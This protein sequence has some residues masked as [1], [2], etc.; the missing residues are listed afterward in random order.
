MSLFT[1]SETAARALN[2]GLR[3][4]R[5][6]QDK[7]RGVLADTAVG[8][9]AGV[10]DAA[11]GV[12]GLAD[13]LVG[14]SLPDWT[15]NPF[16]ERSTVVGGLAQGLSQF[17]VGFIPGLG[18]ASKLGKVRGLGM[19]AGT[20]AK[21]NWA[22]GALGGALADFA[23]FDGHD[24]RLSDM[25]RDHP[26][27]GIISEFL[28]SNENDHELEGRLKN[29]LEG[30]ALDGIMEGLFALR[31][32]YAKARKVVADGGTAD[33]AA[34]A[35]DE[36]VD[37]KEVRK[38]Q[39][40][41][42]D[43]IDDADPS[44]PNRRAAEV[45]PL[46]DVDEAR[47]DKAGA[48]FDADINQPSLD[49]A[50]FVRR[51]F[52]DIRSEH[53]DFQERL[54]QVFDGGLEPTII[55]N[56][57]RVLYWVGRRF[58]EESR[59]GLLKTRGS[60]TI[61]N[62]AEDVATASVGV[63]HAG[64]I[65][66]GFGA[67]LASKFMDVF[68]ENIVADIRRSR[69]AAVEAKLAQ[70]PAF[71]QRLERNDLL[72]E[73]KYLRSDEE[74]VADVGLGQHFPD[75]VAD[76]TLDALQMF[77]ESYEIAL[78][79]V[80]NTWGNQA[81]N[82]ALDIVKFNG[83]AGDLEEITGLSLRN[84]SDENF[85][86]YERTYSK[87]ERTDQVT[88]AAYDLEEL[89]RA[90]DDPA[91]Y[92]GHLER[93]SDP[94]RD[95]V[96]E[97]S[98]EAKGKWRMNTRMYLQG[99][100]RADDGIRMLE[101][102]YG[103][104]GRTASRK[105]LVE[106]RNAGA[107]RLNTLLGRSGRGVEELMTLFLEEGR[108]IVDSI[109]ET[110]VR[111]N[112]Y[113]EF[114]HSAVGA[115]TREI[116]KTVGGYGDDI[117]R[118]LDNLTDERLTEVHFMYR[119]LIDLYDVR[120]LQGEGTGR[121]LRSM[122]A[123][124]GT[125]AINVRTNNKNISKI[126]EGNGGREAM[127]AEVAKAA[128][129]ALDGKPMVSFA[130]L[131]RAKTV[132]RLERI[133]DMAR[134]WYIASLLAGTRTLAL[135]TF[136]IANMYMR[137][138]EKA[139]GAVVG[140]GVQSTAGALKGKPGSVAAQVAG[141]RIRVREELAAAW[142]E[143]RGY[144]KHVMEGLR[145]AFLTVKGQDVRLYRGPDAT[146]V[147]ESA[148]TARK[149]AFSTENAKEVLRDTA[150]GNYIEE[151]GKGSLG[152]IGAQIR[153][154]LMAGGKRFTEGVG[155]L[156]QAVDIG[157]GH[158]LYKSISENE[159][160]RRAIAK[161]IPSDYLDAHVEDVMSRMHENWQAITP[162]RAFEEGQKRG[163]ELGLREKKLKD[164]AMNYAKRKL[165]KDDVGAIS[166]FA[167]N[168]VREMTWKVGFESETINKVSKMLGEMPS[169]TP[170][171]IVAPFRNTP[172]AILKYGV[173]RSPIAFA[174]IATGV[175]AVKIG[176]GALA[177]AQSKIVRELVSSDPREAAQAY[178]K[179]ATATGIMSVG[180]MLAGA[181]II[182]G[183]GP[184]NPAERE[185]MMQA[186]WRPYSIFVGDDPTNPKSGQYISFMKFEQVA[187]SMALIADMVESQRNGA[188]VR[189]LEEASLSEHFAMAL[190]NNVTSRSY[191][192]GLARM[193]EVL[194]RP[195]KL[196]A[197]TQ[198]MTSAFVPNTFDQLLQGLP[199][200]AG[201]DP[202]LREVRS[203]W[204]AF[205]NATI[206]GRSKALPVRRNFMGEPMK[207]R[208]YLG[209]SISP[210][211]EAFSFVEVSEVSDDIIMREIR[212]IGGGFQTPP[213]LRNGVDL[214]KI[215]NPDGTSVY[216]KW[217]ERVSTV[218]V[219]DK[220]LRQAL[221]D[222]IKSPEYKRLDYGVSLGVEDPHKQLIRNVVTRYRQAAWSD[223]VSRS[224]TLQA[225]ETDYQIR[226]AQAR[227]RTLGDIL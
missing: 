22:R 76:D 74:Y 139:L 135:N 110:T 11:Q 225:M 103:D 143:V 201:G 42:D 14:D 127:I 211:I 202:Y 66:R 15:G 132:G 113:A 125:A 209:G 126:I 158:V 219:Q 57:K 108:E 89:A 159:I 77:G 10:H 138:L 26:Q 85:I 217:A 19:L 46:G 174:Q 193:F 205:A 130:K 153:D 166:E 93:F 198:S 24:E 39:R 162:A 94:K 146:I 163:L 83:Q 102:S 197:F 20:S 190:I 97:G 165:A 134:D 54:T 116:E 160:R 40:H 167:L 21:A 186:G 95:G 191:L 55:R 182:T 9:V 56:A 203:K 171:W 149:S 35:F 199:E 137:P 142:N 136:T 6:P 117:I 65:D 183:S 175:S 168:E 1:S 49:D 44:T 4:S 118:G 129:L 157:M 50:K 41:L 106:I 60:G 222:L 67:R 176:G 152:A 104:A 48:K 84:R 156:T 8:L 207:R 188:S 37:E 147:E 213:T 62:L 64:V 45:G 58:G 204:D 101:K 33:D 121:Q 70:D 90:G 23:V 34:K 180:G 18:V 145:A 114:L 148:R 72:P 155:N 81:V 63:A 226:R 99:D 28:G 38:M 161:G 31:R 78:D 173:D 196:T 27:L 212:K 220:T 170:M 105:S 218:T 119:R 187:F 80:R 86:E 141:N 150:L 12:Y 151:A 195:D 224:Q 5:R 122:G 131:G 214:T 185:T 112:A 223:I 208:E 7:Q 73:E 124:V 51:V 179:L 59:R 120:R 221:R 206:P 144:N 25:L 98:E 100:P 140:Y 43:V 111:M 87:H 128:R 13:T 36:S 178:G 30:L 52:K 154:V 177:D 82:D 192:Q 216:D 71:A 53:S 115:W 133:T 47:L 17:T 79:P 123:P 194:Q 210:F 164:Y 227:G 92:E 68:N 16:G 189:Q 96:M 32:G 2:G 69:E 75:D 181:G 88:K 29:V 200:A 107:A 172:L 91:A 169:T 215:L 3:N 109:W 184:T 61:V